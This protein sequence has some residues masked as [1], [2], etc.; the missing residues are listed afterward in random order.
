MQFYPITLTIGAFL[1]FVGSWF[2]SFGKRKLEWM[3]A[4]YTLGFG[5]WLLLPATSLNPSSFANALYFMDEGTWGAIY[6]IVGAFHLFALHV[7]GRA[8]WTPFGRLG[9]VTLNSQVFLAI[10]VGVFPSNP[11][12]SGVFTYG[13]LGIFFCGVCVI[14]A[15]MDCGNE[16]KIWRARN[17]PDQ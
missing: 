7:N 9:A 15:A 8:A 5:I 6:A 17:A 3:L 13:F 11:W 2:T 4:I 10:T 14:S 1:R 12:G 16:Y